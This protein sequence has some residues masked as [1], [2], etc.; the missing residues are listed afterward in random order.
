VSDDLA[1]IEGRCPDCSEDPVATLCADR[2]ALRAEV[3]R[4]RDICAANAESMSE[5]NGVLI[6][7]RAEVEKLRAIAEAAEKYLHAWADY[8]PSP[9]MRVIRRKLWDSVGDWRAAT[10]HKSATGKDG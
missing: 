3:E 6:A 8:L 4:L 5:K 10:E 1:C 9:E 7:L 2:K